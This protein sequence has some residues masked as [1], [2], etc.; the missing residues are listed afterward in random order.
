MF[1]LNGYNHVNVRW[2]PLPI[3]RI[4]QARW[5]IGWWRLF[6][7]PCPGGWSVYFLQARRWLLSPMRAAETLPHSGQGTPWVGD[8]S[9][10]V[11]SLRLFLFSLAAFLLSCSLSCSLVDGMA[12][13]FSVKHFLVT[14][15]VYCS[16][17]WGSGQAHRAVYHETTN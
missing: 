1:S 8:A 10:V 13:I 17:C 4:E 5:F 15:A 16:C 3:Q 11:R 2:N 12:P 7:L 14:R 6:L 9:E